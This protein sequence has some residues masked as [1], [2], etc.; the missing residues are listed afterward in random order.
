MKRFKKPAYYLGIF[1]FYYTFVI[2]KSSAL[3]SR[4]FIEGG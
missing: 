2:G 4:G 3:Q 1:R